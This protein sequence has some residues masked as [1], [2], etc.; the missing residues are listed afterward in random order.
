MLGSKFDSTLLPSRE[1]QT[2]ISATSKLAHLV[3]EGALPAKELINW[4]VAK[5]KT[6]PTLGRARGAALGGGDGV[7]EDDK[8]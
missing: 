3:Q 1:W 6:V 5:S 4:C 7:E 2:L 8:S